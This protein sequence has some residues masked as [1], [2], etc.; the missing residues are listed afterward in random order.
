VS[1]D[2]QITQKR[3]RRGPFHVAVGERDIERLE[4]ALRSGRQVDEPWSTDVTALHL[5]AQEGWLKGVTWL[6]DHGA[7]R[8]ARCSPLG[9]VALHIAAVWG[10]P[11]IIRILLD[12]GE[13]V[14][15]RDKYWRTPLLAAVSSHGESFECARLLI[16]RGAKLE[17]VNRWGYTALGWAAMSNEVPCV[18]LLLEHG[19]NRLVRTRRGET[20]LSLAQT[21]LAFHLEMGDP[22]EQHL[23]DYQ[24]PLLQEVIALLVE[25]E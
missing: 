8:S 1:A 12:R 14:N 11:E 22:K 10:H 23:P 3:P 15:V 4:K 20:P 2:T 24:I 6:L 19:A 18:K 5:A 17:L 25:P 7:N 13:N 21:Q 9:D 16:E